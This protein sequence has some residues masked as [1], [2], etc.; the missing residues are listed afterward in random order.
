VPF[1]QT[2]TSNLTTTF[3]TGAVL[4]AVLLLMGVVAGFLLGYFFY[5]RFSV[6]PDEKQQ[7]LAVMS[8]LAAFTHGFKG[9]LT[10]H[11]EVING[12]TEQFES[13]GNE[14]PSD[15]A[16]GK[17]VKQIT[18]ANRA[19]QERLDTAESTLV[20]QASELQSYM[21]KAHTDTLTSL[22][23]RRAFD[24]EM[25]QRLASWNRYK[26]PVSLVLVDIDHFKRFNDVHGHLAG[27]FVLAQVAK[28]MRS[29][30]RGSD[31]IARYGGEEFAAILPET[32]IPDAG[33]VG[34][35]LLNAVRNASFNYQGKQLNVTISVGVAAVANG[36]NPGSIVSRADK[37]LYESKRA[38]RDCGHSFQNGK[39]A[40]L[41]DSGRVLRPPTG[42][43]QTTPVK[44]YDKET[45]RPSIIEVCDELRQRFL[46]VTQ[47]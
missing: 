29:H 14:L 33:T 44:I 42:D 45:P 30:V 2:V 34:V 5:K 35:S 24:E 7:S 21:S 28:E 20:L 39:F 4:G 46:E 12:L 17:L 23:N 25:Q 36:D 31:I 15:D 22:P 18:E 41:A 26:T 3:I 37:A 16:G 47:R 1:L 43:P 6:S 27:D 13:S 19:L 11:H 10:R 9:D 32:D 38:G 40:P 8:A